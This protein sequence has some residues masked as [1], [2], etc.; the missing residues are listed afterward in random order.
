[1]PSISNLEIFGAGQHNAMSGKINITEA[2][3]DDMV[4]A[5][6]ELNGSNIVKPHLK[7]GHT[8]A[9]KWFGQKDGIPALGWIEKVWRIGGK[10][11]A[12][13][14]NV[15]EALIDLIRQG[16]YHNVSAEVYWDAGIEHKGKKFNRVLSAVSL[17]GVEMPAVKDLAGLANALFKSGPIHQFSA[18]IKPTELTTEKET[19]GMFTQEQVD[20]LIAAAV[21]KAVSDNEAKFTAQVTDLTT[22]LDVVTK[23]KDGLVTELETVKAAAA[24]VEAVALVDAAIKEGKLLPKQRDFALAALSSKDTKIMFGKDEKSMAVMFKEFLAASGKVVDTSEKGDGENKNEK[25]ANAADE[26]DHKAKALVEADT[27]GKT[28]YSQALNKVLAGDADLKQRY[29]VLS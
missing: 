11:F 17:L 3:L 20:S 15:P 12:D 1:M 16:R 19:K 29:L 13:I 18:A 7:L 10:L 25:F 26:V 6:N 28:T 9:Q 5:F 21:T 24:Q 27:T 22:K 2:D 4:T 23:A 14:A 8:D